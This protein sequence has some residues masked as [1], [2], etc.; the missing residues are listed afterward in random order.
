MIDTL[1]DAGFPVQRCCRT[2]GVSEQGYYEYRRRPL[3]P[4]MMRRE[5]LTAHQGGPR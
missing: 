4:T 1:V 3:S 2:L 5:W